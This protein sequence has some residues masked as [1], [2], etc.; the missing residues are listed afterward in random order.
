MTIIYA[1]HQVIIDFSPFCMHKTGQRLPDHFLG[2]ASSKP[3]TGVGP[4]VGHLTS[5]VAG[6]LM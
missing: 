6:D 1:N 2:E 5:I 3:W 4:I